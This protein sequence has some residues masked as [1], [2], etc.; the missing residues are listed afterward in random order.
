MATAGIAGNIA[1]QKLLAK[2]P[3]PTRVIFAGKLLSTALTT[4][5]GLTSRFAFPEQ[6][7]NMDRWMSKN[8][9]APMMKDKELESA[10]DDHHTDRLNQQRHQ[11]DDLAPVR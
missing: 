8:L 6:T 7:R 10:L 4:T 1:T 11:A 9:F 2:N 3:S 5:M